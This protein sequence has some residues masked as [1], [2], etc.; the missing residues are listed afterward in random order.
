M[1]QGNKLGQTIPTSWRS[2]HDLACTTIA[3]V[4]GLVVGW[5]DL[6]V[7]EVVVTIVSL[8]A[9]GLLLGLLQPSAA[10]RWAVLIAIGLPLMATVARLSAMQTAEPARLDARITLVALA[11]GLL[12]SYAG[13]FIRRMV[14]AITSH[15]N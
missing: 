7:T 6:H 15:S 12:G 11:F 14:R 10:W 2:P 5:L 9:V 4:L 1:N 8:L 3:L 13:V